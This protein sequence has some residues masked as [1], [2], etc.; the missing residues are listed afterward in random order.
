M[1]VVFSAPTVLTGGFCSGLEFGRY[2]AE[3]IPDS[4]SQTKGTRYGMF[5]ASSVSNLHVRV[6]GDRIFFDISPSI[7]LPF[8]RREFVTLGPASEVHH[9]PVVAFG[10]AWA[11][12]VSFR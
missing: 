4:A 3:G 5:W 2:M 1:G 6:E 9:I 10:V 8:V 7:R 11:I 12:G